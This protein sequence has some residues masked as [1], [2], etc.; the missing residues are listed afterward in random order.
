MRSDSRCY[1]SSL[2]YIV[3]SPPRF[4]TM[5]TVENTIMSPSFRYV[6]TNDN[7]FTCFEMR[8][9]T[10]TDQGLDRFVIRLQRITSGGNGGVLLRFSHKDTQ[11]VLLHDMC[12]TVSSANPNHV[13]EIVGY[14]VSVVNLC[15]IAY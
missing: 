9:K 12:L 2:V 14:E 15:Y 7:R 13:K 1:K 10:P 8:T 5:N 4:N 3:H 11:A 6:F